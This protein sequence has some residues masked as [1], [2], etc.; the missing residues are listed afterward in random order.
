MS[1][2]VIPAKSLTFFR[3][4][5]LRRFRW[6]NN[7]CHLKIALGLRYWVE[8]FRNYV[9]QHFLITHNIPHLAIPIIQGDQKFPKL[10]PLILALVSMPSKQLLI[11][12]TLKGTYKVF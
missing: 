1:I 8:K 4:Q 5:L 9:P 2:S 3:Y 12:P 11:S 7:I 10:L 6:L